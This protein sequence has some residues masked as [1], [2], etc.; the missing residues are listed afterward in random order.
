MTQDSTILLFHKTVKWRQF[1]ADL[2]YTQP[3]IKFTCLFINSL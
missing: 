1:R 2:Q 3:C